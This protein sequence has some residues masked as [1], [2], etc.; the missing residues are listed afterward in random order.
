MLHLED[1]KKSDGSEQIICIQYNW[2]EMRFFNGLNA[3][4]FLSTWLMLRD[5]DS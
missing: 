4:A 2:K 5:P 3:N 1:S